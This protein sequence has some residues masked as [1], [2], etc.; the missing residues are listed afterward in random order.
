MGSSAGPTAVMR[1][2][3]QQLRELL[4]AGKLSLADEDATAFTGLA[5][6]LLTM[7][8]QHNLKEE[9]ILYRMCDS[10]LGA[11][12]RGTRAGAATGDRRVVP[13]TIDGRFMQPP[14]PLERTLAALEELAV[15]DELTLLVNHR[16]RCCSCS[17]TPASSGRKRCSRAART[18][19]ASATPC[20]G[21]GRRPP[22]RP[23]EGSATDGEP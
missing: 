5:E 10:M 9:H 7:L 20:Q 12:V 15:G 8:Q 19:C 22:S 2:E 4:E 16:S 13:L 11:Q 1:S 18:S 23:S 21:R 14:E 3:H 6:T 17:R